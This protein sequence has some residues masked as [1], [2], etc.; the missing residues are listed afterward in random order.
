MKYGEYAVYG[1]SLCV[2]KSSV[3]VSVGGFGEFG[4]SKSKKMHVYTYTERYY[5]T[6]IENDI[7]YTKQYKL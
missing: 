4:E 6:Q 7:H 3:F 2:L 1:A 5:R